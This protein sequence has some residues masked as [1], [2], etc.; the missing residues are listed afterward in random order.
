[1]PFCPP[2]SNGCPLAPRQAIL[3]AALAGHI[4]LLFVDSQHGCAAAGQLSKEAC[5]QEEDN[6][7]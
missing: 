2:A 4:L 7:G 1:M 5:S 3:D 6:A